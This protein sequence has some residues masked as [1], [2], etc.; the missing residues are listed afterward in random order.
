[1]EAP[2]CRCFL[3][4]V[5]GFEPTAP[6]SQS[7]CAT[8]LRHTPGA[9]R[10]SVRT[11]VVCGVGARCAW[12]TNP[13]CPWWARCGGPPACRRGAKSRWRERGA[14][15]AP[16][17]H[18]AAPASVP[19]RGKVALEGALGAHFAPRGH[20]AAARQHAVEGQSRVGGSAGPT[21]PL[22]GTLRRPAN[23]PP[24]GKVALVGAR[25]RLCPSWARCAGRQ[26]AAEG[27]SR[28]SED[29]RGL[30]QLRLLVS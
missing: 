22:V 21:L 24:R 15:F 28:T 5:A 11:S 6:R 17:G 14:D 20:A 23:M 16:R 3:V 12:P 18:A 29:K 25:G 13:L 8:K 7:E 30:L 10:P 1:M 9:D 19:S 27:Q 4:G 2:E 26:H